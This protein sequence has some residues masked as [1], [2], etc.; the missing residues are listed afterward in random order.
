M[1]H[2]QKE[3]SNNK[4]CWRLNKI[5]AYSYRGLAPAECKWEY[6]FNSDSHLIYGPN[7][8]GKSSILG[9][10]TWC[11]T[12]RIFRDDC[13]PQEPG[14]IDLYPASKTDK[15]RTLHPDAL[16]LLDKAG[17]NIDSA[18]EYYVKLEL[19]ETLGDGTSKKIHVQRHSA[20]GL[21]S[22]EDGERWLTLSNLAELGINPLDL[23]LSLL[24]PAKIPHLKFGENPDLVKLFSEIIGIDDFSK[25]IELATSI[26]TALK[27]S[28]TK[29][30]KD[31]GGTELKESI[32]NAQQSL[33][34]IDLE[35]KVQKLN[36]ET[37]LDDDILKEIVQDLETVSKSVLDGK[38]QLAVSLG[39]DVPP[40]GSPEYQVFV[41]KAKDLSSRIKT[42]M[43]R[44]SDPSCIRKICSVCDSGSIPSKTKLMTLRESLDDLTKEARRKIKDRLD[45]A[46]K[47]VDDPK[48]YLKLVASDFV[49]ENNTECPLCE[50]DFNDNPNLFSELLSLKPLAEQDHIKQKFIDLE[51][52]LKT[53]LEDHQSF[54]QGTN[55]SVDECIKNDWRVFKEQSFGGILL[56][57]ANRYDDSVEELC[58]K[59]KRLEFN[60][61]IDLLGDH[62]EQFADKFIGLKELILKIRRYLNFV[63]MVRENSDLLFN[64]LNQI[65]IS[66]NDNGEK[67][68]RQILKQGEDSN[69]RLNVLEPLEVILLSIKK[70]FELYLKK[71]K[72]IKLKQSVAEDTE[73]LKKLSETVRKLVIDNVKSVEGKMKKLYSNLYHDDILE[74]DS[75]TPGHAKNPNVKTQFNIYLRADQK[76]VPVLPFSN[77]GKIRALCLSFIFA[78][79]ERSSGSIGFLILD[80]PIVSLDD[81]HRSRFVNHFVAPKIESHQVILASHYE[82]FSK[83]TSAYFKNHQHLRLIPRRSTQCRVAFEP[84]DLL[85]RLEKSL[86]S[87]GDEWEA[88]SINLRLWIERALMTI[89]SY[90]SKPFFVYNNLKETIQ[91]YEKLAHED[92]ATELRGNFLDALNSPQISQIKNSPAH[93]AEP[94]TK[95]EVIDALKKLKNEAEAP[96]RKIVDRLKLLNR[97]YLQGQMIAEDHTVRLE[98]LSLEKKFDYP[99]TVCGQAAA[100][101]GGVGVLWE[102]DISS[103]LVGIQQAILISNV[104]SPVAQENQILLL[105]S[106]DCLPE[107]GDLVLARTSAGKKYARRYWKHKNHIS[108]ECVNLTEPIS[109]VVL[110]AESCEV[111]RILGIYFDGPD[112][113]RGANVGNEWANYEKQLFEKIKG[114]RVVGTSMEPIARHGQI[115]LIHDEDK[116]KKVGE[117]DLVCVDGEGLSPVIKRCFP[118]GDK[119]IL[120]SINPDVPEV[121]IEIEISKIQNVYVL[122]GVL[123]EVKS[124]LESS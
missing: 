95:P 3:Q 7:G 77:A 62:S 60:P 66:G 6:D 75:L 88:R 118:K 67:S 98:V 57:I 70:Q 46:L 64:D 23:E 29:A 36:T 17:S 61:D 37:E 84:G 22:S 114:V 5:T 100:A 51:N 102:E 80:D 108:L 15:K 93:Y 122:A 33:V 58:K 11:L 109:P 30:N 28:A 83:K 99:L 105:D 104:I 78:L 117:N 53:K 120:C 71:L 106:E 79:I 111:R 13:A 49:E 115:I 20:S 97:H 63:E 38:T 44:I 35:L 4:A 41:A 82:D 68:L 26:T 19:S 12:G 27:T 74:L 124:E 16:S 25:I 91:N 43:E 123:F 94:L 52:E 87:E 10:I 50:H 40:F 81:E 113:V 32:Q 69:N 1:G 18:G 101:S 31:L 72:E 121:P 47:E 116:I 39:L 86:A 103:N 24:M 110:S 8:S 45:W 65:V 42:V 119:W 9:A 14:E 21:T 55:I 96:F 56:E 48:A 107:D 92:I 54:L 34:E 89:S 73:C 59:I 112:K 2:F 90:C 85:L 76:L